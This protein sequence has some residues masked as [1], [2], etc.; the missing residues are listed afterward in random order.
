M[1]RV[2][3]AAWAAFLLIGFAMPA[4]GQGAPPKLAYINSNVILQNTPGRAEA[5]STF[6]RE[7]AV[8]QQ[9]VNVLQSQF[10]SAVSEFN[11]TSLV[12][13]PSAKQQRQTELSQLQQRTQQQV[14][15]LRDS[16]SV[17]EQQ[18]MAP[19]MQRVQAVIEGIR[20]E[21]NYAMIFDAAAQGGSLIS[22]DRS[23]DLS[24][25]VIQRL[26]AGGGQPAPAV[27]PSATPPLPA[28]P[29]DSAAQRPAARPPR[30]TRPPRP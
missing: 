20:A 21:G 29:A 4:R 2:S 23:L 14:Q 10:D 11:R 25:L 15:S 9:Q 8:M 22:A 24:Q 17:R 26:Q 5:E 12:L 3:G 28:Q 16:A 19:I 30:G 1:V 27:Q 18:L 6:Q 13:S 7:L